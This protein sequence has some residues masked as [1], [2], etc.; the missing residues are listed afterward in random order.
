MAPKHK[1]QWTFET[2]VIRNIKIIITSLIIKY[3]INLIIN[4]YDMH[5]KI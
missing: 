5:N 3:I 1:V 2:H 4:N